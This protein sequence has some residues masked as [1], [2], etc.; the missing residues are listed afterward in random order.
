MSN[1]QLEKWEHRADLDA[2]KQLIQANHRNETTIVVRVRCPRCDGAGRTVTQGPPIDRLECCP[3]C[4][5]VGMAAF[6]WT[7]TVTPRALRADERRTEERER[8]EKILSSIAG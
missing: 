6:D 2:K 4:K 3:V 1:T 5:G 7:R 8:A